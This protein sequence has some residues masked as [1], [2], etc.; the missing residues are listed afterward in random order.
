MNRVLRVDPIA[1]TRHGLCT[2]LL[3]ERIRLDDW[4]YPIVDPQPITS[5]LQQHARRAVAACPTLALRL[6]EARGQR[7]APAG[8]APSAA[9][10][11]RRDE[12]A[13][14][15]SRVQAPRVPAGVAHERPPVEPLRREVIAVRL[16][17]REPVRR[18]DRMGDW[19]SIVVRPR[20][21]GRR[22]RRIRPSGGLT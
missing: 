19:T 15:A 10:P 2:E 5:D 20:S 1:C 22:E 11:G 7:S 17:I 9:G 16:D 18:Q 8:R 12:S 4:G 21:A 3:P 6:V 14:Q 13:E